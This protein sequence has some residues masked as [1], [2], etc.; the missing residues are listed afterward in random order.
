MGRRGSWEERGL[1]E[2]VWGGTGTSWAVSGWGRGRCSRSGQRDAGLE[3]RGRRW[4]EPRR[5]RVERGPPRPMAAACPGLRLLP[6]CVL[7]RR[8]ASRVLR[9]YLGPHAAAC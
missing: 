4:R 1:R 6:V 8:A 2:A 9:A 3:L 7:G 5:Y